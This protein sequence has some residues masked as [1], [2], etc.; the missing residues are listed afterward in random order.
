MERVEVENQYEEIS[1]NPE[2]IEIGKS[3]ICCHPSTFKLVSFF[4]RKY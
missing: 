2:A 1:L 4:C 3:G